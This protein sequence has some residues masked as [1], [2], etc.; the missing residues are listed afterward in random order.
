MQAGICTLMFQSLLMALTAHSAYMSCIRQMQA[1]RHGRLQLFCSERTRLMWMSFITT[2]STISG[3]R[4]NQQN[5][6]NMQLLHHRQARSQWQRQATGRDGENICMKLHV[7][8]KSAQT[9]GGFILINM[10][11]TRIFITA[12]HMTTL[13]HGLLRH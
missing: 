4:T 1:Q 3:T 9:T 6:L 2:E 10:A 11:T 8:C 13:P 7:R 12:I 5:I